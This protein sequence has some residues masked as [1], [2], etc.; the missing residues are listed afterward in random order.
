M[1]PRHICRD[2]SSRMTC[3]KWLT[4]SSSTSKQLARAPYGLD[5]TVTNV[6]ILERQPHYHPG[7][8]VLSA[9]FLQSTASAR[10][11]SGDTDW[12]T[13]GG[14]TYCLL[15]AVETCHCVCSSIMSSRT[16]SQAPST[17]HDHSDHNTH[18]RGPASTSTK[19]RDQLANLVSSESGS[20][21]VVC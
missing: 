20:N 17:D 15:D 16:L 21:A 13:L 4:E 1:P 18:A 19:H 6:F 7:Q 9:R 14:F 5:L 3:S 11:I 10:L 2:M 8:F 12:W